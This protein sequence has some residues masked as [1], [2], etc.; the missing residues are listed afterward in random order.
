M[1]TK[2]EK[3]EKERKKEEKR[4]FKKSLGKDSNTLNAAVNF[5]TYH[6]LYLNDA[7]CNEITYLEPSLK[8]IP[9]KGKGVFTMYNALKKRIGAYR[10]VEAKINLDKD[11]LASL[12]S[13]YD[14]FF[15]DKVKKL[16]TQVTQTLKKHGVE[17]PEWIASVETAHALLSFT[18]NVTKNVT[19]L[20]CEYEKGI[21]ALQKLLPSDMMSIMDNFCDYIYIAAHIKNKINLNEEPNVMEAMNNLSVAF[22]RPENVNNAL[23]AARQ[24]IKEQGSESLYI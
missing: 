19:E 14:E 5:C 24:E 2:S 21:T 1:A 22:F 16:R 18:I 23:N 9:Y 12:F 4:E 17:N 8:K 6:I 7:V 3:R 20:L 15:D 13:Q 10:E 11:S